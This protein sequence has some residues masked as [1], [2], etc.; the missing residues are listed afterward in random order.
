MARLTR[1]HFAELLESPVGGGMRG[2][3]GVYDSASTDLQQDKDVENSKRSRT[4]TK[5]S[6]AR[7]A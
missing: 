3:I 5:K 4:T 6:Q 2:D 7:I 1:D